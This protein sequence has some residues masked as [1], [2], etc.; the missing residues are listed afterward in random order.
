MAPG[1]ILALM[2]NYLIGT[3]HYFAIKQH[4]RTLFYPWRRQLFEYEEGAEMIGV[5]ANK[6]VSKIADLYLRLFAAVIRLT[7]ILI[8][9]MIE[10]LILIGFTVFLFIWILWPV[11]LLISLAKGFSLLL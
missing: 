4:S 6:I 1:K 3:W 2:R 9:L 8:G 10:L 7:I 11:V 5:I